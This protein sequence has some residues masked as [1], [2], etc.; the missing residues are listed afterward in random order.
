MQAKCCPGGLSCSENE[1]TRPAVGCSALQNY[2]KIRHRAI[3]A[4]IN[5]DKPAPSPEAVHMP[6]GENVNNNIQTNE[7]TNPFKT[8]D[9]IWKL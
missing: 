1:T 8:D 9:D 7:E 4:G 5:F 6:E 2:K 3:F